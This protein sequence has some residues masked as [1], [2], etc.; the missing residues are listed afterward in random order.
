MSLESQIASALAGLRSRPARRASQL[1]KGIA[2]E[3][4]HG[5]TVRW[6]QKH[7]KATARQVAARI[8]R[9][10]LREDPHYYDKLEAVEGKVKRQPGLKPPRIKLLG[11]RG[12]VRIYLVDTTAAKRIYADWTE[13][14]H[15]VC[16]PQFVPRNEV[17]IASNLPPLELRLTMLHELRERRGMLKL[18]GQGMSRADAYDKAHDESLA[19]EDKYRKANGR[20]LKRALATERGQ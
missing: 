7:P 8:A 11:R 1:R 2:A 14:G 20:G 15:D 4:E 19:V 3:M 10:H 12:P 16:Y 17:W 18:M 5:R 13:G 9:D 6:A